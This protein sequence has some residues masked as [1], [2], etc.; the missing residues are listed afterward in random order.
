MWFSIRIFTPIFLPYSASCRNESAVRLTSHASAD[1]PP[2]LARSVGAP[3]AAARSIHCLIAETD[4]AR[5]DPSGP[6][7]FSDP[8][9]GMLRIL[10]QPAAAAALIFWQ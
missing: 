6:D 9:P 5:F 8:S 7:S 3:T 1:P 10:E 2:V 4:A